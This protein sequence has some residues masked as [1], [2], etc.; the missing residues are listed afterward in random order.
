V[1]SASPGR[2]ASRRRQCAS[3]GASVS[4]Q[5]RARCQ[6]AKSAYCT[7]RSGSASGRPAAN[8]S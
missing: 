4:G 3:E 5:S 2:S 8:A 1:G 6:R 7:G